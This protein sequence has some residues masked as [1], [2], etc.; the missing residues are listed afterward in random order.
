MKY[1]YSSHEDC[2][3]DQPHHPPSA[4]HLN[5]SWRLHEDY[6]QMMDRR[7]IENFD[8]SI[9]WVLIGII[10]I[11]LLSIYSALYNQIQAHPTHNL[12]IRQLIWLCVGFAIMFCS[13]AG[14]L[15]RVEEGEPVA[16]SSGALFAARGLAHWQGCQ[17]FET[18]AGAGRISISAIGIHEDGHCD[19]SCKLFFFPGNSPLPQPEKACASSWLL[20]WY[21]CS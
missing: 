9:I 6:P 19:L 5:W 8:W 2:P 21:R 3:D 10:A 14:R 20:S 11:G 1:P 16:L 13:Y 18:L 4:I 15:S 12:F 17:R 7:L